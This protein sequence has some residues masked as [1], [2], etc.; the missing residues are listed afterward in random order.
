M[1]VLAGEQ[2]RARTSASGAA[3]LTC[4][5]CGAG[6]L[7]TFVNLGATPSCEGLDTVD[8][9]AGFATAV[10][11]VR[12]DLLR[13]LLARRQRARP[14]SATAPRARATPCSTICGIRPDLLQCTV[15]RNP[16]KHG[17]RIPN[18]SPERIDAARPD[19]VLVLP[20]NLRAELT[21]Q[22]AHISSWG[23][24]LVFPIPAPEVVVS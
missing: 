5:L 22:L 2:A 21:E 17:T 4:R 10:D 8:G 20:W 13:F 24:Q 3:A 18:H 14:W 12:A 15:D 1:T 11:R 16:Y 19:Y 9:H 7:E 6:S 23:G